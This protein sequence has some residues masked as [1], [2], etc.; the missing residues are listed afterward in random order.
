MQVFRG[1]AFCDWLLTALTIEEKSHDAMLLLSSLAPAADV[2]RSSENITPP[3]HAGEI[4]VLCHA[5]VNRSSR[6]A[7]LMSNSHRRHGQDK[8]KQFCLVRVGG[9][10]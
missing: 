4:H 7:T 5:M 1:L 6:H 10:K 3:S 2:S 8:T 9:V